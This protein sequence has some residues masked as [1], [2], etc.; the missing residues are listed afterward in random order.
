MKNSFIHRFIYLF[1]FIIVS[2]L[3]YFNSMLPLSPAAP[4]TQIKKRILSFL[5]RVEVMCFCDFPNLILSRYSSFGL[6]ALHI[7]SCL[8]AS[9]FLALLSLSLNLA[10][11]FITFQS[12][13]L[14]H[15]L[16]FSN[17]MK[18][19]PLFKH[20]TTGIKRKKHRE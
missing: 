11:N 14:S 6:A 13:T 3:C 12:S 20:S 2:F 17:Q 19:K 8:I 5:K 9:H 15:K 7:I 10:L 18:V 16:Q 1:T 4:Q